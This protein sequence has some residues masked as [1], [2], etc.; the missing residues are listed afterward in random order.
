MVTRQLGLNIEG[1]TKQRGKLSN[2]ANSA[3]R[4]DFETYN[5]NRNQPL[6]RMLQIFDAALAIVILFNISLESGSIYY[7]IA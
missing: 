6:I 3:M 4:Q 5:S 7:F 1:F 2:G